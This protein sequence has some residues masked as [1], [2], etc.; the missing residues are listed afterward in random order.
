MPANANIADWVGWLDF[1]SVEGL[2]ECLKINNRT[3][4]RTGCM[5]CLAGAL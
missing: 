2:R 4:A 5:L 3:G 1:S